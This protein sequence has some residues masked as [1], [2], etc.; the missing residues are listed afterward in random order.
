M[1]KGLPAQKE[2]VEEASARLRKSR[3]NPKPPWV[4]VP[5]ALHRILPTPPHQPSPAMG[6]AEGADL[7]APASRWPRCWTSWRSRWRRPGWSRVRTWSGCSGTGGPWAHSRRSSQRSRSSRPA[8]REHRASSQSLSAADLRSP[9]LRGRATAL[10][11]CPAHRTRVNTRVCASLLQTCGARASAG[12]LP[13]FPSVL[14]QDTCEHPSVCLSAADLRSLGLRGRATAL[15]KCP[16]PGHV[17]TPECVNKA[18]A[19]IGL[20]LSLINTVRPGGCPIPKQ[21]RHPSPKALWSL[22]QKPQRRAQGAET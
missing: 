18:V 2:S 20:T 9:G 12:E 1:V 6:R 4:A 19:S 10:P 7:R 11:K 14:P 13:P 3:Y 8:R 22:R 16:T 5:L 15:P 17:W 21:K